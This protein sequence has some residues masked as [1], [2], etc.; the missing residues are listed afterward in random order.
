MYGKL[1][2]TIFFLVEGFFLVVFFNLS[3]LH[4]TVRKVLKGA[5]CDLTSD[6]SLQS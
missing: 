5:F 4:L 2:Q 3:T 6:L 1:S